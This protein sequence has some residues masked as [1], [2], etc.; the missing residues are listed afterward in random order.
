[1]LGK[2]G[3]EVIYYNGKPVER[4]TSAKTEFWPED[5]HFEEKAAEGAPMTFSEHVTDLGDVSEEQ[6][7]AARSSKVLTDRVLNS[8][9][10]DAPIKKGYEKE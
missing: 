9:R 6:R 5:S 3:F 2:P 7:E 4:D 1:M 10:W 8:P